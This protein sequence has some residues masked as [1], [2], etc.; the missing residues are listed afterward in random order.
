MDDKEIEVRE[1]IVS[2]LTRRG[3]GVNTPIRRLTQVFEK[4]GTLIAEYDPSP[5]EA[6]TRIDMVA[7]ANYLNSKPDYYV[8]ITVKHLTDW[9]KSKE[10]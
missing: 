1:V 2:H 5:T 4:D 7:F 8:E 10:S 9:L 6:F 3:D